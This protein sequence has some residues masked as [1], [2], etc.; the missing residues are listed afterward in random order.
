MKN[1]LLK[2]LNTLNENSSIKDIQEYA[3][4]MIEERGFEDETP[5][6]ILMLLTEELGELAKE[7]RK[8]TSIKIDVNKTKRESHI[9]EEIA[10]VFNYLLAM[11]RATNV[12][13]FEAFKKKEEINMKRTW[14]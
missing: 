7:V 13:L 10:D 5:Q 14:K 1:E 11:C 2:K 9:E 12:N 3:N 4:K 6:D 8:S